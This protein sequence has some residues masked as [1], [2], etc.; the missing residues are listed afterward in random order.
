[1]PESMRIRNIIANLAVRDAMTGAYS[2]I[3]IEKNI[4]FVIDRISN[5]KNKAFYRSAI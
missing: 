4:Q 5:P 3:G 1:M 2:R